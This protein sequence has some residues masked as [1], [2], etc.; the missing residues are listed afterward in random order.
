MPIKWSTKQRCVAPKKQ[1]LPFHGLGKHDTIKLKEF[2]CLFADGRE[3]SVS[4]QRQK[5]ASC[6]LTASGVLARM[7]ATPKHRQH[8]QAFRLYRAL[9]EATQ[10]EN[11]LGARRYKGVFETIN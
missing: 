4:L 1:R 9:A 8:Y 2:V 10:I 7:L 3:Q 11:C 6:L 5:N